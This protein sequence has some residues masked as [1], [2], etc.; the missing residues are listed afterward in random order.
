M[1][2]AT[3][4]ARASAAMLKSCYR[5]ALGRARVALTWEDRLDALT[6]AERLRH[7]ILADKG[8]YRL[9]VVDYSMKAVCAKA[10]RQAVRRV[11]SLDGKSFAPFA[12]AFQARIDAL[13]ASWVR[14]VR[15]LA[16]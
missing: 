16:A 12:P 5:A 14:P 3:E 8:R 13:K 4:T 15:A 6:K 2:S 1:A 9:S 10:D 11:F 7:R